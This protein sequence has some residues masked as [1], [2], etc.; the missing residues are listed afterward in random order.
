MRLARLLCGLPG[1]GRRRLSP[2][3]RRC[4]L[5]IH[6]SLVIRR[7]GLPTGRTWRR[8]SLAKHLALGLAHHRGAAAGG[9]EPGSGGLVDAA[10]VDSA[11]SGRLAPAHRGTS[12]TRAGA[13]GQHRP[14]HRSKRRLG[15][16]LHAARRRA[17]RRRGPRG[18]APAA[19][20]GSVVDAL[21]AGAAAA[22]QS[23]ADR[24]RPA[25]GAAQRAGQL[26]CRRA[27]P[28]QRRRR[29]GDRRQRCGRLV[30]RT[31]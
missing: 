29:P 4:L 20:V 6:A 5:F 31:T 1:P 19:G 12:R 3:V 8:L 16:S 21:V 30:F 25:G 11:A 13:T 26:V 7:C 18:A 28:G 22:F 2:A 17:A 14:D 24:R 23:A 9:M 15:A 10:L 27:G